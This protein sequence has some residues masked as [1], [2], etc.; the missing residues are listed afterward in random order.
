LLKLSS[1]KGIISKEVNT[2]SRS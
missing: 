1:I 2:T